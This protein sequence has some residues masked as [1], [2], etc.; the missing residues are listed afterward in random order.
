MLALVR[1]LRKRG[2]QHILAYSLRLP[3][4]C[5]CPSD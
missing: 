3:L 5:S 2:C 1:S 4:R